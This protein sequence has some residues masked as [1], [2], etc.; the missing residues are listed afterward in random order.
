M[1]AEVRVSKA[2]VGSNVRVQV[3]IEPG[4]TPEQI[5]GIIKNVYSNGEIY[6]VGGL[7]P[8]LTCKS[9]LDVSIVESFG[10]AI[11]VDSGT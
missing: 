4:A 2:A 5:A 10:N 9:G 7:R 11:S 8:C 3:A 6:R 1:K